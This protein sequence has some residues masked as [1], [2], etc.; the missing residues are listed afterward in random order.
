MNPDAGAQ[1]SAV[2]D[3][4]ISHAKWRLVPFFILLYT[5]AH[6]DRSN[7]GF[8]KQALQAATG[9]SDAA[10]AFGAGAFFLTYAVSEVPSNLIMHRVGAKLWMTRIMVTWGLV[11]ACMMFAASDWSFCAVRMLLGFAEGG[12]FPGVILY[13]TYW[14]PAKAR[15]QIIGTF[16][17]GSPIALMI[18]GPLAGLLFQL[19][20]VAGLAGWQ[21]LYIVEGLGTACV[22]IWTFFFLTDRPEKASWLPQEERDALTQAV[23]A[24]EE[25]KKVVGKVQ[26]GAALRD[27]RLW[28]FV[29][30]LFFITCNTYAV[31][32][33]LPSVV[34]GLL[35][36]K[37]GLLVGLV[38]AIPYCCSIFAAAFWPHLAVR[39]NHRQL[40]AFISLGAVAA[41]LVVA[42]NVSP[43]LAIIAF[44]FVTAGIT[45]SQPI[46]WTFPSEYLGGTAAA[47]GIGLINAAGNL[48]GFFGPNIKAFCDSAFQ[49]HSAGLYAIAV[50]A[51]A[52]ALLIGL[53]RRPAVSIAPAEPGAD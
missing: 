5:L 4:A 11:A 48:G 29:V 37:V 33:Y 16:F 3:R 30:I 24:E 40:F 13:F 7:V 2:L 46:F 41:G 36:V 43:V 51:L 50:G 1:R 52:A 49:S 26:F 10:Y 35:H 25:H 42:M 8:A 28:H 20:G 39:T 38:T 12:F 44:C 6:L 45:S 27:I 18:G 47:G 19:D 31:A 22:G 17:F 23:L 14:F 53:L 15:G 21:W 9:L 34:S 32:F